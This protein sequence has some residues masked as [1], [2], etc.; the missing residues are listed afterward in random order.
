[1]FGDRQRPMVLVLGLGESGLAIARWCARHGCRLRI[2]DTREAPPNLAA[3]QAEGIDAEFVGGAFTPALLDGGVEIVGLSPGLSPLEPALAALVA[4]ANERGVAVWGELEFFAQALRALGTSGYQPKVLAITGTN[5]KT[6]TTSLTGLLCQR[7][8]KKVAV[9]GNISPAMLDRLASAIDETAL[10]DVWVLELSSFQLET[11]RTFA[12]D[13]A[14][15]LNITQDHLDWHGS[16]DAYAQAKGR[17]FGAT[18]TRVLNRDDAAVMKFAPAVAAADAPRTVTFGLNEPTQDGDYGLSRDNGI[19]WL[20]EAVDRDAP[21]EATTTR[22][23]KRDA[24]HTPDIAQKRLMPADA[25]RIRGLHNAANA[26][27]AF[28]LARAIDLPAAPLLHALREYRGEAHRVEVIATIDDVDYVD[29]SKG[30]NV[31]AT[32]AA[33]DGLAQ[34]I[35]LIAG[36]DGKGQD[37]AP[38]V[39]PVARWCRAVML[40]GRDAPVIRDTLAETGVPLADHATL[41]AAVHAAAELAEPG[42]AVLLSPACA[43][44]DMFRNYAHRAEVF[45]AAVDAIAIDKGATP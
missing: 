5:G 23:R 26:L 6:T 29:D 31:G 27:A 36:G 39:A 3:L 8:G 37:F 41:E 12:P 18:T 33:L 43:S 9:A 42:D 32:V 21:D 13:A 34:K 45:R 25:L 30:T 28:A 10:P 1:M 17:I 44:L 40:I 7:S 22:R 15:I 4:A 24:A 38:L 16:F 2:A 14:A 35:V 20:V 19:A 11:A